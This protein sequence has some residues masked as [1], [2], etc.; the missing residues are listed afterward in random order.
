MSTLITEKA[1][2][3][4]LSPQLSNIFIWAIKTVDAVI[5]EMEVLA[6]P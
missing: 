5:I 6:T 1:N 4:L 3:R 2:S